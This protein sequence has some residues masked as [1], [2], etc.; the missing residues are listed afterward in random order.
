MWHRKNRRE[1][2]WV[3]WGEGERERGRETGGGITA[4]HS[5]VTPRN[6]QEPNHCTFSVFHKPSCRPQLETFVTLSCHDKLLTQHKYALLPLI[7][8]NLSSFLLL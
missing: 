2:S 4:A 8:Q 5:K 1:E 7:S 6:L 3:E